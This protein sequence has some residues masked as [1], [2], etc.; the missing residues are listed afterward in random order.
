[1]KKLVCFL[2]AFIV[3][4]SVA[5]ADTKPAKIGALTYIGSDEDGVK[6]W[7][8]Q[9]AEAEGKEAGYVN[10]HS[11]VLFDNLTSMLMALRAGQID[12]FGICS[13]TGAYIAARN[14]DIKVLDK[15][16]KAILGYSLAM[17]EKDKSQVEAINEAIVAMK[18]DG[19]LD[20]LVDEYITQ[21]KGEPAPVY[22]QKIDGADTL[23]IAITGD[24]PPMDCIL[25]D[26]T[27]AGF[28][29]AFLGELTKRIKKNFRIVSIDSAAR[30][31]SLSSGNVDVLFWTQGTFNEN[32][33]K[34]PY[35]LDH[36][37]GV[38]I[39][40][41]YFQDRRVGVTMK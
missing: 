35:P 40:I 18:A 19:S 16:Y 7:T 25:S 28:N 32:G 2:C 22:L 23:K 5:V 6:R 33:E 38:A 11:I 1:M 17:L 3:L 37:D 13:T 27:P 20:K 31:T 10:P 24:L 12:R 8:E 26:G 39:S 34:L 29:V 21:R 4:G 15:H 30:A 41:P 14:P 9:V 36:M